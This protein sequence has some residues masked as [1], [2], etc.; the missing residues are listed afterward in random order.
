MAG[1]LSLKTGISQPGYMKDV[2]ENPRLD[3][4]WAKPRTREVPIKATEGWSGVTALCGGVVPAVLETYDCS[5]VVEGA[6]GGF[7]FRAEDELPRAW[8]AS[9]S[10]LT[11]SEDVAQSVGDTELTVVLARTTVGFCRRF[12]TGT[13]P[14]SSPFSETAANSDS[15]TEATWPFRSARSLETHDFKNYHRVR[16]A[17]YDFRQTDGLFVPL[18]RA[19]IH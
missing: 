3:I 12:F 6:D 1:T 9:L 11:G 18:A 16:D 17:R 2:A 14:V 7:W 10:G 15:A 13:K 4:L 5:G 19:S 8:G